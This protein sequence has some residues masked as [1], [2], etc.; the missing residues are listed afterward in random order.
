MQD[1]EVRL[2]IVGGYYIRNHARRNNN[3]LLY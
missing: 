1:V 3:V 2:I